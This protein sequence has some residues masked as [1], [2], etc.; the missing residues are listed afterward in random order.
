M[1]AV[2]SLITAWIVFK[3]FPALFFMFFISMLGTNGLG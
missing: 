3:L 2:V 1:G